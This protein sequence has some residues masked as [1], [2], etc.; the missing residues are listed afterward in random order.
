MSFQDSQWRDQGAR[1]PTNSEVC[2]DGEWS[3]E[4]SHAV[5]SSL[6]CVQDVEFGCE[7]VGVAQ[8]LMAAVAGRKVQACQG[9]G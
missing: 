3:Q 4:L 7:E 9:P 6:S 8:A 1:A 2:L 5:G